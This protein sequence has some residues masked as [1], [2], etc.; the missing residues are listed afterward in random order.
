VSVEVSFGRW[1]R[2][3]WVPSVVRLGPR[4]VRLEWW[5]LAVEID[6]EPVRIPAGAAAAAALVGTAVLMGACK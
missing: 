6:D 5:K 2:P 4:W 3:S 1:P